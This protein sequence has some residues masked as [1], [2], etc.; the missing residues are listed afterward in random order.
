MGLDLSR[1]DAWTREMLEA[2]ARRRRIRNPEFRTRGDLIRL[3]LKHQYGDRVSA[4]RERIAQGMRTARQARELFGLAMD[5]ALSALPEPIGTLVRLRSGRAPARTGRVPAT[6]AQSPSPIQ[7]PSPSP[8][9]SPSPSPSPIQ[10]PSPDT[11]SDPDTVT[12]TD[13]PAIEPTTRTF[14]EEPI[15]TRTM[16]RLLAAQGHRERALLIYEELLAQN[17][18]D[19]AMHE[20]AE[21]VRRGESP[22]EWQLPE[23]AFDAERWAPPGTDDHLT[24]EGDAREGLVLRWSVSEAGQLRA[25]AVLGERGELALRIVSIQ[26]DPQRVVRSRITEHGPVSEHGEWHAPPLQ[27]GARCF[28]AVGLRTGQRFVAIVHAHPR[29]RVAI[30]QAA[31]DAAAL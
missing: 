10:S 19:G 16:A 17:G 24:C 27:E 8:I 30:A 18:P 6:E 14:E 5:A 31:Q 26:A 20:E 21:A 13:R 1:I 15:R 23:P 4:G 28:A 11:D 25:G 2:E 7:S 29:T 3:L 22:Q 9:Q 12:F